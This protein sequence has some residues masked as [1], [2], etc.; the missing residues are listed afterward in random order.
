MTAALWHKTLASQSRR[1]GAC[2]S[3]A[4]GEDVRQRVRAHRQRHLAG[5]AHGAAELHRL[6]RYQGRRRRRP[7]GRRAEALAP[8]GV[9]DLNSVA[10]GMMDT[11]MQRSTETDLAR[12]RAAPI[13]TPS[14][15]SGR[16]ACRSAGGPRSTRSRPASCGWPSMRPPYVTAERLNLS[17]GL[18]KGLIVT[19]IRNHPPADRRP[20]GAERPCRSAC[21]ATC[22]TMARGPGQGYVGQGLGIADVLAALYFH[23]LRWD[24]VDLGCA[25]S[26]PLPPLDRPLLDRAVGG[27]GR[28]RRRSARANSANLWRR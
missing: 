9:L 20:A 1:A 18:D 11:E 19:S 6:C 27:A 28:G 15:T 13:S 26:R 5:L 12:A 16:G 2:G 3:A 23:E 17:G 24:P 4:A 14:S 7:P 22:S 25:R 10:P 21:A 8:H